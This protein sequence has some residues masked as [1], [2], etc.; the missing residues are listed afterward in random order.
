VT[1]IVQDFSRSPVSRFFHS[2]QRP[3]ADRIGGPSG[4]AGAEYLK[5]PPN[6]A[7]LIEKV[8]LQVA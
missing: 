5:P 3:A 8:A 6:D 7:T 2:S 1:I 4:E